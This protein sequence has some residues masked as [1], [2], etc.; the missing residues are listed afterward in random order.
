MEVP[1]NTNKEE[2]EYWILI[3]NQVKYLI[4]APDT[5]SR[6]TL[7]FPIGDL[8]SLPCYSDWTVAY[9]FR[10]KTTN[11][12]QTALSN[13]PLTGVR[14]TWHVNMV[15]VLSLQ[16]VERLSPWTFGAVIIANANANAAAVP[17]E[18][19]VI[20]KIARFEWEIPRIE[21]ETNAYRLLEGTG[22]VPRFLRHVHEHGR[23]MDILI[24]KIDGGCEAGIGDLERCEAVLR[25]LHEEVGLVHGDANRFNFIVCEDDEVKLVDFENSKVIGKDKTA[26]DRLAM[27]KEMQ[28]LRD[29]LLETT[30]RGGGF[31]FVDDS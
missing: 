20:A 9:I 1:K 22:L 30:G 5:Y 31:R 25:R 15:D 28:G 26:D 29:Q 17:S 3:N 10:D 8:P 7:S 12:I 27:E 14:D 18:A 4:I 16:R 13:C 19:V 2:S 24:E 21:R 6:A 11:D 23:V